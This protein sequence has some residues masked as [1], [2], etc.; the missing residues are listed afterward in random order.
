MIT[1]N[2]EE[3]YKKLLS[4]RTHGITRDV[5][6][7]VNSIEF[8]NGQN[9]QISYPGWYMEMQTLGYNYRLTDFQAALGISQLKRNKEGLLRREQIAECYEKAFEGKPFILGQPG[10]VVGHAYHLYII[11]V[12]NRLGLYNFLRL[13]KIFAQVHYIPVHL[14]PYYKQFG[15][16]EGDMPIA[17]E[18][19]KKCISLPMYPTLTSEEQEFVINKIKEYYKK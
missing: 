11:E 1:T 7:F 9:E 6:H 19:Y 17:E 4:L 18:Y 12:K 5:N 13:K 14:M 8:A 15:W 16:K 2:N 3:L 10:K